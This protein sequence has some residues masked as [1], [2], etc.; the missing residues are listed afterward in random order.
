MRAERGR[1]RKVLKALSARVRCICPL[2]DAVLADSEACYSDSAA[3]QK[4]GI[5]MRLRTVLGVSAA[6]APMWRM[7]QL[8]AADAVGVHGTP[9]CVGRRI[10]DGSNDLH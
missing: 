1:R 10:S 4:G 8:A 2:G 9:R 7:P 6:A 3:S 5:M